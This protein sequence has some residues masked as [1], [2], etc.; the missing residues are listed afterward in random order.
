MS[1]YAL[2]MYSPADR[3]INC[4][5]A[6]RADALKLLSKELGFS[7]TDKADVDWPEDC[8]M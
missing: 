2:H 6:T 5:A 8:M 3:T 4:S 7:V 1:N